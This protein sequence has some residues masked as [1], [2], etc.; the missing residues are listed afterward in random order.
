MLLAARAVRSYRLFV[1]ASVLAAVM[2]AGYIS[3]YKKTPRCRYWYSVTTYGLYTDSDC[4]RD[5]YR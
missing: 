4:V 5:V 3:E 2:S 1:P